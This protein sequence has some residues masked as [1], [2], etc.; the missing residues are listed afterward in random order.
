MSTYCWKCPKGRCDTKLENTDRFKPPVCK[1]GYTMIRDYKAE[2]V[3]NDF[4][5]TND[6]YA[7]KVTKGASKKKGKK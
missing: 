3:T 4:H 2:N 5:P 7:K 1:C 6:L